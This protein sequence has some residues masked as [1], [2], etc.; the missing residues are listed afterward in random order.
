MTNIDDLPRPHLESS[1]KTHSRRINL[2]ASLWAHKFLVFVIFSVVTGIGTTLILLLP[3]V[4][5]TEAVLEVLPNNIGNLRQ[6]RELDFIRSRGFLETQVY[7]IKNFDV[8]LDAVLHLDAPEGKTELSTPNAEELAEVLQRTID[9]KQLPGTYRLIVS[10]RADDP[11]GLAEKVNAVVR[12][13]HEKMVKNKFFGKDIRIKNLTE[14]KTELQAELRTLIAHKDRL[15]EEL[16]P[17]PFRDQPENPYEQIFVN[18]LEAHTKSQRDRLNLEN[19]LAAVEA[20]VEDLNEIK[21]QQVTPEMLERDAY[22]AASSVILNERLAILKTKLTRLS[23]THPGR[24]ALEEDITAIEAELTA[25]ATSARQRIVEKLRSDQKARLEEEITNLKEKIEKARFLENRIGLELQEIKKKLTRADSLYTEFANLHDRINRARQQISA[26]DDRLDFFELEENAPGFVNIVSLARH[27]K[28]PLPSKTNKF[29][30]ALLIAA[31]TL[32]GTTAVA[33]DYFSPWI[34][35][36]SDIESILHYPPL[37]WIPECNH[38]RL[39]ALAVDQKRRLALAVQRQHVDAGKRYFALTSVKQGGGTTTLTF[40]LAQQL[41]QFGL[42]AL[43]IEANAFKPDPAYRDNGSNAG[44]ISVLTEQVPLNKVIRSGTTSLPARI[45]IGDSLGNQHLP[46]NPESF[47]L[48]RNTEYDII[49]FDTPPILLS[50]DAELFSRLVDGT[51][52]IV[53]AEG[54]TQGELRRAAKLLNQISP[55]LFA[56]IVNRVRLYSGWG[57]FSKLVKEYEMGIKEPSENNRKKTQP[58]ETSRATYFRMIINDKDDN[59]YAFK[60]YKLTVDGNNYFGTTNRDGLVE[61]VIPA[62]SRMGTLRLIHSSNGAVHY[63]G[64]IWNFS[65][66]DPEKTEIS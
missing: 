42:K 5:Y 4:Y 31:L 12:A 48:L 23:G 14:R 3:P 29:L 52:L 36:P 56:V 38:K 17:L 50:S 49:L 53:E 61:Q 66:E 64:A 13:Y 11:S 10:T 22:F 33:I 57:Y 37:G 51:L 32:S 44:L 62:S 8:L 15:V 63:N 6:D 19:N 18:T 59:P 26:I 45:P 25:E 58:S 60:D 9:V 43:A 65:L 27:P 55:S 28:E 2:L 34:K 16:G 24:F 1:Q 35:S 46:I 39:T 40:E 54:V 47:S 7:A 30:I 41:A 20:K 21:L